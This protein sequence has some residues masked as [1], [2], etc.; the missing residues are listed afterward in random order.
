MDVLAAFVHS[1]ELLVV[2]SNS[3]VETKRKAKRIPSQIEHDTPTRQVCEQHFFGI[4]DKFHTSKYTYTRYISLRRRRKY[5]FHVSIFFC[6][7]NWL[8]ILQLGSRRYLSACLASKKNY[9]LF[10]LSDRCNVWKFS[11]FSFYLTYYNAIHFVRKS[12]NS[13]KSPINCKPFQ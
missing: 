10:C 8:R 5:L 3:F 6:M 11:N 7:S 12:P 9:F 4:D 2:C 13:I 1:P